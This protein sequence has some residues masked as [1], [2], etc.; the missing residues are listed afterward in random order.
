[1]VQIYTRL[2]VFLW[3]SLLSIQDEMSHLPSV[4]DFR[5]EKWHLI[6]MVAVLDFGHVSYI[7]WGACMQFEQCLN[8]FG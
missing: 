7:C 4:V 1:M 8:K 2:L 6:R 3:V 5:P